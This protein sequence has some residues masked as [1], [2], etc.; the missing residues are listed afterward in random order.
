MTK[1]ILFTIK[2]GGV[3]K[4]TLA[5]NQ[6]SLLAL[7]NKKVLM[8]DLDPQGHVLAVFGKNPSNIKKNISLLAT[9]KAKLE[10]IVKKVQLDE[11]TTMDVIPANADLQDFY[12]DKRTNY[13]LIATTIINISKT[14]KYDYVVIDTKPNWDDLISLC[15]QFA[16]L[17]VSPILSG[18]K[19]VFALDD[20]KQVLE[21]LEQANKKTKTIIVP[22]RFTIKMKK[23]K[24]T[25]EK[26]QVKDR[27]SDFLPVIKNKFKG[28]KNVTVAEPINNS[29][30]IENADSYFNKPIVCIKGVTAFNKAK[31]QQRALNELIVK[32]L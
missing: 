22:N 26:K 18:T 2:K 16:D 4:T 25:G 5:T 17:V 13:Q 27:S 21:Y 11:K 3:G 12:D 30:Q 29:E 1:T 6:A 15:V 7:N 14:N 9:K 24:K 8:I 20:L 31:R 10:E 19:M 23:D 32:N 28:M